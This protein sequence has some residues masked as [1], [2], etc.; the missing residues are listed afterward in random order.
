MILIATH[1]GGGC[2]YRFPISGNASAGHADIS[3]RNF[4][5]ENIFKERKRIFL[6]IGEEYFQRG[7]GAYS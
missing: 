5:K 1:G 6:K 4:E 2:S 3:V 7:G